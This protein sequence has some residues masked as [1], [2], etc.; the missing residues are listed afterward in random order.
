M[1]FRRGDLTIREAAAIL[2]HCLYMTLRITERRIGGNAGEW[3]RAAAAGD[4]GGKVRPA[5]GWLL[6]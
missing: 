5:P 6:Q 1:L 3:R 2:S 4:G